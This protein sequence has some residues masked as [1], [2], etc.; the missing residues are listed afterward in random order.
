MTTS[1]GFFPTL[2][3]AHHEDDLV[4]WATGPL[5]FKPTRVATTATDLVRVS[6]A[7]WS[8]S[9][10]HVFDNHTEADPNANAVYSHTVAVA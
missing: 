5:F 6:V 9:W 2:P 1:P 4:T 3:P 10:D 8:S 7:G